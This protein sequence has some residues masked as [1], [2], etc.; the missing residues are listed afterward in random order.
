MNRERQK[1]FEAVWRTVHPWSCLSFFKS[2]KFKEKL[3]YLSLIS[4]NCKS[5]NFWE[6]GGW[7]SR[8]SSRE[9][10]GIWW[11][12]FWMESFIHFSI[13]QLPL[14]CPLLLRIVKYETRRCIRCGEATEKHTELWGSSILFG[15]SRQVFMIMGELHTQRMEIL[16]YKPDSR[17]QLLRLLCSCVSLTHECRKNQ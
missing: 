9:D 10:N 6:D 4:L 14:E 1:S 12:W 11:L 8:L 7:G 17:R 16:I 3:H 13:H 5:G 15:S 2:R